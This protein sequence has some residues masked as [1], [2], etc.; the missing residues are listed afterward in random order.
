MELDL[1]PG[2]GMNSLALSARQVP[3][4]MEVSGRCLTCG[5]VCDSDID[6]ADVADDFWFDFSLPE[7]QSASDLR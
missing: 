1:C 2:C 3:G 7:E 6:S 4:G 5:Y